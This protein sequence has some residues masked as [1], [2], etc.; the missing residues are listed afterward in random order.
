MFVG[1]LRI[2][3]NRV[4]TVGDLQSPV[5]MLGKILDY[6]EFSGSEQHGHAAMVGVDCVNLAFRKRGDLDGRTQERSVA[7]LGPNSRGLVKMLSW[8]VVRLGYIDNLYIVACEPSKR[9]G[10]FNAAF[11]GSVGYIRLGAW[12]LQVYDTNK[13][14]LWCY[15]NSADGR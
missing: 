3:S 7:A 11:G 15:P 2:D 4:R 5:W 6:G 12:Y 13:N 9:Q 1:K 8:E 14:S 10:H